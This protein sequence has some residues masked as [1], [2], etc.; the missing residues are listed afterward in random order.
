ME[1]GIS[2]TLDIGVSGKTLMAPLG[3]A[4]RG[5]HFR[6]RCKQPPPPPPPTTNKTRNL[7]NAPCNTLTF[8]DIS[9]KISSQIMRCLVSREQSHQPP[10]QHIQ[11]LQPW[12]LM[13]VVPQ[14]QGRRI[15]Q[16]LIDKLQ[17]AGNL[18]PTCP[19]LSKSQS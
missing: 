1:G 17:F 2:G 14:K 7:A 11:L 3:M 5:F 6:F 12:T 19:G 16:I 4:P 18:H 13:G 9:A 15:S 10:P 8:F